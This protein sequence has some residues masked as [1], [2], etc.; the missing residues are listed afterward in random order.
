MKKFRKKTVLVDAIEITHET[1]HV[2]HPSPL[3]IP[4]VIYDPRTRTA[5]VK[6]R[7]GPHLEGAIGDWLV[8]DANGTLSFW[9]A[10]TFE[11]TYDPV[12]ETA[13]D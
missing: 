1:F 11:A 2:P 12:D 6:D 10:E 5:K 4:G 13:H 8:R 3:H 9:P 7:E